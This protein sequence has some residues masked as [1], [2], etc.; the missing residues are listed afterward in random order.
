MR[1]MYVSLLRLAAVTINML[2]YCVMSTCAAHNECSCCHHLASATLAV[3]AETTA[4]ALIKR[5]IYLISFSSFYLQNMN[6]SFGRE[7][8]FG[9][10]K[11][12]WNKISCSLSTE[13]SETNEG[14]WEMNSMADKH[15]NTMFQHDMTCSTANNKAKQK[16][17][18]TQS[19]IERKW[20]ISYDHANN[21]LSKNF[22][23][24][25]KLITFHVP[26]LFYIF[27]TTDCGLVNFKKIFSFCLKRFL[28]CVWW[29]FVIKLNR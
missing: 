16:K 10:E 15:M 14:I 4:M 25:K 5:G 9:E 2:P 6:S 11:K 17:K 3:A 26:F 19:D 21:I 7:N 24:T 27:F 20:R 18:E 29:V 13:R 22:L 28:I 1:K 23:N 12:L 8:G